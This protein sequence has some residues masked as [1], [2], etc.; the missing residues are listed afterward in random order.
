MFENFFVSKIDSPKSAIA[1]QL[2]YIA[3]LLTYPVCSYSSLKLLEPHPVTSL[4]VS[5]LLSTIPPKSSCLDYIPTAIIKQ[6]SSVLS[7]FI[8]YLANLSFSQ[9]TFPSKF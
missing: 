2:I 7:E 5:K 6:R 3:P 1:S 9:G 4:D 8:A